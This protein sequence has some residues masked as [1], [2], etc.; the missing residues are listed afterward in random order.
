MDKDKML[1]CLRALNES[2]QAYYPTLELSVNFNISV[3]NNF[4][5]HFSHSNLAEFMDLACEKTENPDQ[6]IRYFCGICWRKIKA[7]QNEEPLFQYA[8]NTNSIPDD[9]CSS[10]VVH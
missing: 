7:R 1:K 6:A 3:I 9:E 8:K 10:R 4:Y 2:F 5:S